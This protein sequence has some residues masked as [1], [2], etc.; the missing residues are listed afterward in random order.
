[1]TESAAI[2]FAQSELRG[3]QHLR[4]INPNNDSAKA[5]VFD[6]RMRYADALIAEGFT[7]QANA[8]L[9]QAKYDR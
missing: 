6:N 2:A 4:R 7:A 1:M 5:L 3:S 8:I 9:A